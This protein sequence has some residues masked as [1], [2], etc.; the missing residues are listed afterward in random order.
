MWLTEINEEN[1]DRYEIFEVDDKCFYRL[2]EEDAPKQKNRRY[3]DTFKDPA[4]VQ[5]TINRKL[6]LIKKFKNKN[7]DLPHL[8]ERWKLL[9]EECI[10]TMEKEYEIKPSELFQIF[11]LD[12]YGFNI[13]DYE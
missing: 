2:K 5:K 3:S 10:I 12:K 8:I 13:D 7:G 6:N 9:I 1:K 4:F 11:Q